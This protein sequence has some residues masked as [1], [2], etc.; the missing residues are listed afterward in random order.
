MNRAQTMNPATFAEPLCLLGEMDNKPPDLTVPRA[1][2]MDSGC[3]QAQPRAGHTAGV[4]PYSSTW[5]RIQRFR[6]VG[7][8]PASPKSTPHPQLQPTVGLCR[9]S[10]QPLTKP[11]TKRKLFLKQQQ[12]KPT[13]L[14]AACAGDGKSLQRGKGYWGGGGGGGQADA[15]ER[16]GETEI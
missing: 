8:V 15:A 14:H 2:C 9:P 16:R 11:L 12:Q 4:Y 7:A 10:K 6:G 5:Q 1:E 13:F 3:C